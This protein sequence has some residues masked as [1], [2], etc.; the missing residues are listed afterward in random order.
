MKYLRMTRVLLWWLLMFIL[1]GEDRYNYQ[2]SKERGVDVFKSK[3][4]VFYIDI[5]YRKS[6]PVRR[7]LTWKEFISGYDSEW[8]RK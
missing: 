5:E 4:G 8:R 7:Y 3:H 2:L 6:K 1:S